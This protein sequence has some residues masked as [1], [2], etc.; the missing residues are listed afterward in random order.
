M[1]DIYNESILFI[2]AAD[3]SEVSPFC[4]KTENEILITAQWQYW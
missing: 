4:Q 3:F 2:F 1:N